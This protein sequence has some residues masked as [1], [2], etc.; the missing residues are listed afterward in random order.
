M[1][2]MAQQTGLAED[3]STDSDEYLFRFFRPHWSGKVKRGASPY[4]RLKD[5][6]LVRATTN[7][8]ALLGICSEKVWASRVE[9]LRFAIVQT[10]VQDHCYRRF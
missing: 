6:R 5:E 1:I 9:R 3:V 7:R 8:M 4:T 10:L 2:D